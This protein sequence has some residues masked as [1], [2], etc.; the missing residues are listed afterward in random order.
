MFD[1]TESSAKYALKNSYFWLHLVVD[2]SKYA[3]GTV[4]NITFISPSKV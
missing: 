3:D 4:F 1:L 2:L